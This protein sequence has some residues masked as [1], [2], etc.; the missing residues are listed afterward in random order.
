MWVLRA[1]DAD[2]DDLEREFTLPQDFEPPGQVGLSPALR[3]SRPLSRYLAHEVAKWYG[4]PIPQDAR[5]AFS[6]DFEDEA[7]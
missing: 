3:A 7:H 5:I 2:T 1:Y 4:L 6:L